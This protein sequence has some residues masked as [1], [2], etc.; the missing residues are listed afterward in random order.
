MLALLRRLL[1]P[2][3]PIQR[4]AQDQARVVHACTRLT[5][6]HA[7]GCPYCTRVRRTLRQLNLP[8]PLRNI[9]ADGAAR[10][11]L[12]RGGGSAQVPCLHIATDEAE[13]RWLYESADIVAYLNRRFEP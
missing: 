2:S 3:P 9:S 13:E 12:V 8:I 10:R 4:T 1:A 11:D 7:P 5:L 6:Y